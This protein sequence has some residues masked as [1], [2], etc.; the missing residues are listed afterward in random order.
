VVVVVVVLLLLLHVPIVASSIHSCSLHL[1]YCRVCHTNHG[2][3]SA[4]ALSCLLGANNGVH[5]WQ[6]N[7]S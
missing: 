1:Q 7:S 2:A 6:R 3:S 4:G 5:N